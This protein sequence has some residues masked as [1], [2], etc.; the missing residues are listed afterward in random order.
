MQW[1]VGR[2]P[3]EIN[4]SDFHLNKPSPVTTRIRSMLQ[5][6]LRSLLFTEGTLSDFVIFWLNMEMLGIGVLDSGISDESD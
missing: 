6:T 5:R 1:F 3:E 4:G 2:W